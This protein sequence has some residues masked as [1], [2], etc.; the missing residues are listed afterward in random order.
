MPSLFTIAGY[1]VFFW[2]NEYGE[3][4][5]VHVCKG[6]P[7]PNMGD[8]RGWLRVEAHYLN[9]QVSGVIEVF[10][11][12]FNAFV[13]LPKCLRAKIETIQQAAPAQKGIGK[14]ADSYLGVI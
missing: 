7:S 5:H 12:S 3:P 14:R 10:Y 13:L 1:R 9:M 11:A 6:M 2:A 4:I 8:C